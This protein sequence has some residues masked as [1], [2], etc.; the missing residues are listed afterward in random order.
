MLAALP[1]I[2][3]LEMLLQAVNIDINSV[4]KKK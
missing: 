4:P 2:L 3:A 1:V